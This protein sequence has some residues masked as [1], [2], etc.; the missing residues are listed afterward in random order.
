VTVQNKV[1]SDA[2]KALHAA[3]AAGF[4]PFDVGAEGLRLWWYRGGPWEA[5]GSLRLRGRG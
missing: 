3:L 4:A 2:A 1:T 5:A